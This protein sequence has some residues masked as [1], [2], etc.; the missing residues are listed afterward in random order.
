MLVCV[1]VVCVVVVVVVVVVGAV[2][3][4]GGCGC[5]ST[6]LVVLGWRVRG[7][8]LIREIVEGHSSCVRDE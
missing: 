4:D 5:N 7:L 3:F 2:D 6:V 1:V 8:P